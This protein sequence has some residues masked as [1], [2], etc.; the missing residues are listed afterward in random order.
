MGMSVGELTVSLGVQ[1]SEGSV[2]LQRWTMAMTGAVAAGQAIVDVLI[3]AAEKF[4]QLAVNAM[5]SAV[6]INT[7][8]AQTGLSGESM[9]KWDM[10]ARQAN[11]SAG[12]L[13]NTI[14]TLQHN[15]EE[16][17]LGS[18]NIKPFQLMGIN[19]TS[20][21]PY[22]LLSSMRDWY[23]SMND[24]GMA[25]NI[26]QQAGITPDMLQLLKLTNDELKRFDS[27]PIIT[28]DQDKKLL[29]LHSAF[30]KFNL[31]MQVTMSQFVAALAPALIKVFDAIS[32]AVLHFGGIVEM[33]IGWIREFQAV[34]GLLLAYFYG[35]SIA[36]AV[37]NLLTNPIAQA[38]AAIIALFL[39]LDD[40]SVYFKG[41]KSITGV[42]LQ[43]MN[44]FFDFIISKVKELINYIDEI[45]KK[46][47]LVNPLMSA[48]KGL[49][50][51]ITSIVN[52]QSTA[53][54]VT[55]WVVNL[56]QNITGHNAAEIGKHAGA[57]VNDAITQKQV[58]EA[59]SQTR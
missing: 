41:G 45:I 46:L 52:P 35:A 29:A 43:G 42:A 14:V 23:Q 18:G 20:L 7:F 28:K 50:P 13:S 24:K 44:K 39:I 10:V 34:I 15:I 21:N 49:N 27:I 2:A 36:T 47:S 1:D 5:D 40:L 33:C 38:A 12:T 58:D 32:T 16:I 19:P 26:L 9:Q 6:A 31:V 8:E 25:A 55:T 51:V 37:T 56:T 48:M 4:E 11:L 22:Q 53:K 17:R 54:G 30:V 3:Q 57:G 59:A